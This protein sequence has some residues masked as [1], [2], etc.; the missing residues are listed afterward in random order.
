[1][2][3]NNRQKD[4]GASKAAKGILGSLDRR[5]VEPAGILV[6]FWGWIL[7]ISI[8]YLTF[9]EIFREPER[10]WV[11]RWLVAYAIY[12][13]IL[14][15]VRKTLSQHYDSPIFRAVRILFNLLAITILIGIAPTGRYLLVLAYTVPI[16]AAIVYFHEINWIKLAV[17]VLAIIGLFVASVEST[18]GNQSGFPQFL[19]LMLLLTTLSYAFE[20]FR[21]RVNLVPSRLTEIAKELHK[22]LDL[23]QLMTGILE[24]TVEITQAQRGLIVVINPRTKRYAGHYLHNFT[25]KEGQSIDGLARMCYVLIHGQPFDSPDLIATFNNKSIYH[26]FFDSQ[27][28][29]VVAEP[30]YSKTGNVMGVIN[31]AHN[32]PNGFDTISKNLLKEFSFLISNS[33]E[34]CLEHREVKLRE[35]K[36]REVG[37]KFVSASSEDEAVHILIEEVR[38]Q[39][40]QAEKLTLH[41]FLPKN[42]GLLPIHTFSP[43]TTPKMFIWSS[44]KPRG[45]KPDF[46]LGYGIAGHALELKDTILVPDVNHHP[47]FVKLGPA[48]NIKSLLVAPLFDPKDNELYGTLSLENAKSFAF[49]LEDESTLAYLATQASRAIAKARDFQAWREQGGILRQI[50]EHIKAYDL[51]KPEH[52][53]LQKITDAAANLLGF[54][55][56]RIRLLD[57]NNQ[58]STKAV[59]GVLD[60]TREKLM[61]VDIPYDELKPFLNEKFRA[62]SSYLI[63]H[64]D[65]NWKQFV[66]KY[67]HVYQP[68]KDKK[69]GWHAYDALITP[70][71]DSSGNSLGILTLDLPKTDTEPNQQV[72]ESIGVFASSVS[73]MIELNRFQKRLT[74]QRHRAQSF[75]NTISHEL[76]KCR[77]LPTICEV[78][79]Q[80]GAKLLSAEGC[81]LYLV[82]G[83]EIELTR[84][85]YLANTDYISRRKPIST[86][87]KSGLTA[88]VAA[89]GKSI[90][91]NNEIYKE[92]EAWAKEI[93][94]LQF[95]PSKKCQSLM[96]APIKDK[97]GKV[98]GVL[99]LENKTTLT[100]LKDF[101][102]EDKTRLISLA[103]E[104]AR[105][106]EVI[107]LY[108][109]IRE[110]ERTGLADDLHD[111][112]NWYHSGVVMWIEALEAW[113][114]QREFEKV[115]ELLP[116]LRRHALTTVIELKEL[117]SNV[118]KNSFEAENLKQ[119][120]Q[121]TMLAWK[122]R[123]TPKY[124]KNMQI[125]LECIEDL[126]IP[127]GIKNTLVRI[128]SLAFS[129]AVQHSGIIEDPSIKV[130]VRVKQ[131]GNR[132]TL[133]V[134]DNGRGIN[135]KKTPEGFGLGRMRQLADKINT[136]G[137]IKSKF[138]IETGIN[139]G[140]KV[141][142]HLEVKNQNS[143][144]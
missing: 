96:L 3:N 30:L 16:F 11:V 136:W 126:A 71:L 80:V 87:P 4:V 132:I 123:V 54:K 100:G 77:D 92:H 93:E 55:I 91:F 47:W 53:I 118:L 108:D 88:W 124:K 102:K 25:L 107:G 70:L 78:V 72:L 59:T 109:D 1:M 34:N 115:E 33:I 134:I 42:G 131:N 144:T 58:L 13:V 141:L 18:I 57:E 66:D 26:K 17:F 51:S 46:R 119:S 125:G 69:H 45:I 104:F 112:I 7:L 95:L 139:Q 76:A 128:T 60:N 74:E 22:T 140:T 2:V 143:L 10:T 83:N 94:H 24:H 29:S 35:A 121:E 36:S 101:D 31:I 137:D 120:L 8:A 84:S 62:E 138:K 49:N 65:A 114:R 113:F 90:Y 99:T 44:P 116:E 81:S 61:R 6:R 19:V 50:L 106:L 28:R 39:I 67:F 86:L 133:E 75:I 130:L 41:Q 82:H 73:W 38:Q 32:D 68:K 20:V 5:L 23:Q 37:E 79:V 129:N 97:G 48:E 9:F 15:T 111:L 127:P 14:E 52:E 63:K 98:I 12:L 135:F 105:A 103:N 89:T 21:R 85:N 122:N 142:L 40:P 27:P 64:G 110:W 56:A 43:E 117:H